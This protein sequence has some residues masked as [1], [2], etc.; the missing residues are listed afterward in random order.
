M[1]EGR[2]KQ[3]EALFAE[4][5]TG[6]AERCFLDIL[7]A[8]PSNREAL[9][10]MGVVRHAQGNLEEARRYFLEALSPGGH[11]PDALSNLEA[12]FKDESLR[13]RPRAAGDREDQAALAEQ[14]DPSGYRELQMNG[15]SKSGGT[16]WGERF[17]RHALRAIHYLNGSIL[18]VG[19]NDG[20]AMR[21]FREANR[22]V[23]GM[24]I[25]PLRVIEALASGLP[26]LCLDVNQLHLVSGHLHVDHIFCSHTLEHTLNPALVLRELALIAGH[27]M[28]LVVPKE[29][30]IPKENPSHC[31]V[32]SSQEA[33]R[34]M[35]PP[36]WEI[37]EIWEQHDI[38]PEIVTIIEKKK[39]DGA[40]P[41][42]P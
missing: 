19:C 6:E 41:Q 32:F 17:R 24:D 37:L 40:T 14:P 3:G 38:E 33:I 12:L 10:N 31:W 15:S 34:N 22:P 13:E 42:T 25:N 8:D 2:L 39:I 28:Y 11:Y 23:L 30:S 16:M 5:R 7:A 36:E 27:R 21:I 1:I 9:N 20:C 4:G 26:A 18:D 29:S 35:V